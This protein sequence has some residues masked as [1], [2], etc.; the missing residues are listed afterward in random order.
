ARLILPFTRYSF[1]LTVD[2]K[3]NFLLIGIFRLLRSAIPR[4]GCRT[5]L[6]KTTPNK[7]SRLVSFVP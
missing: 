7:M 5:A 2:K 3:T 4:L 6:I 1:L